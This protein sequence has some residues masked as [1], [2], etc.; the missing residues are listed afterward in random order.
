MNIYTG[1]FAKI[2]QYKKDGLIPIAIS[3]GVPEF[4]QNI[5]RLEMFEP[6]FKTLLDYKYKRITEKEYIQ[7]YRR[8]VLYYLDAQLIYEMLTRKYKNQNIILLCYESPK[9]FCHRQIVAQWFNNNGIVVKEY[10]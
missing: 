4:C 2:N 7:Q 5:D 6:S 1:Y 10:E 9:F 3:R 8:D